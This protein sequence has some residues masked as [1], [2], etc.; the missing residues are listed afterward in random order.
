MISPR[1]ARYVKR[2]DDETCRTR[3]DRGYAAPFIPQR[4]D[5]RCLSVVLTQIPIEPCGLEWEVN[6][7][8]GNCYSSIVHRTCLSQ[9]NVRVLHERT[10][11]R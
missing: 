6:E 10:P 5:V 8:I 7:D 1:R 11:R 4:A 9:T 2:L 3:I